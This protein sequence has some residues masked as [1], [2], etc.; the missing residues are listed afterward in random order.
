MLPFRDHNPSF[1]KPYVTYA[2]ISM[3]C[4][5]FWGYWG[6]LDNYR[7]VLDIYEKWAL[8]PSRIGQGQGFE[9]L[10]TSAFLHGGFWHLTGNM[11]FLHIYGDNLE[12]EMGHSK[13]LC[14]YLLCALAAGLTQI[15]SD[16]ES[17]VPVVGASGAVAGVM[18]G[19]LFLFPKAKIDVLFIFVIFFKIF[20]LPA[21]VILGF[22]FTLQLIN[23]F[24]VPS[25]AV[26]VAYWAHI[27]GFVT[28][29]LLCWPFFQR[30]GGSN[31]WHATGGRP[32]HPDAEYRLSSSRIPKIR[33]EPR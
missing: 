1:R 20:S 10:I 24:L 19:Y 17:S 6:D 16:P 8:I 27:G 30:R 13:F 15:V 29:L 5:I 23:G 28:G 21:W 3:N 33:R 31:F 26:G 18:G 25:D 9:T 7:M 32:P 4:L 12:D 11:L 2:L 14:F 22:W